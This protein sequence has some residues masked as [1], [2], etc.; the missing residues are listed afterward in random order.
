MQLF[1]KEIC[2]CG[3]FFVILHG[4]CAIGQRSV[5]KTYDLQRIYTRS[6]AVCKRKQDS[7]LN[8]YLRLHHRHLDQAV[9]SDAPFG[10]RDAELRSQWPMIDQVTLARA[11]N[12]VLLL[13]VTKPDDGQP[14]LQ[15]EDLTRM[16]NRLAVRLQISAVE[17]IVQ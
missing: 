11:D 17:V 8:I 2:K 6:T 9:H 7:W 1:L 14:V 12:A 5:R 4:F 16:Q 13:T 15:P 10:R 3:K